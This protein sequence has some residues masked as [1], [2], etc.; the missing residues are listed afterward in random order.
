MDP[1]ET[2]MNEHRFIERVLG[3]FEFYAEQLASGQEVDLGDYKL[4][5][6][7][8]REFADRCHH[9]KEEKI[10]FSAMQQYGFSSEAG[11]LAVM[12]AEHTEGRRLVGL[13]SEQS[14][15]QGSWSS[16]DKTMI[17]DTLNEFSSLLLEHIDKE[18]NVLYPMAQ[19]RVP[20][21]VFE[22]MAVRFAKFEETEM[23]SG[24]HERLHQLAEGLVEKYGGGGC[25]EPC[26][27]CGCSEN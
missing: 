11:P 16:S 25:S 10:L 19:S 4:F 8:I 20:A 14:E 2:L 9:G 27:G 7:F 26:G 22:E 5:V 1:I 23:G 24:E 6:R 12:L 3:A 17:R 15:R 13:L 18:D 21:D